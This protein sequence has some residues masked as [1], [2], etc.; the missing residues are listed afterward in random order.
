MEHGTDYAEVRSG[1]GNYGA[2]QP[3]GGE[4]FQVRMPGEERLT[5]EELVGQTQSYSMAPLPGEAKYAGM[6][7]A[8][9]EFFARWSV[10]GVLRVKTECWVVGWRTA[11][12]N[13][14]QSTWLGQRV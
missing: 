1:Y 4:T 14:A 5:W 11:V 2:L 3:Y 8:L 7:R 13:G 9:R 6:Q 10:D 12:V